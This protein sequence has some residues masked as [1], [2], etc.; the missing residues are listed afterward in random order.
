MSAAVA[1]FESFQSLDYI[2]VAATTAVCYDYTLTF[3]R[4]VEL[5]WMK[6]WSMVSTLFV[7][8]R[9]VGLVLTVI[10]GLGSGYGIFFMSQSACITVAQFLIW[11][12][13]VYTVAMDGI[14]ILRASVMFSQPKRIGCILSFLYSLVTVN[15]IVFTFLWYGP[16]SGL[17]V[18]AERLVDGTYC[19]TQ[20]GGSEIVSIYDGIPRVL[21]DILLMVLVIYRFTIH[22]IETQRMIARRKINKYM[23]LL[24][25]HSALYFLLNLAYGGFAT[26]MVLSSSTL[27]QMLAFL[28][29]STVPFMIYP[30]LVLS[31]KGYRAAS[32][33][34]YV[35][36][37]GPG[38][39]HSHSHSRRLSGPAV[40][41]G[42]Y[43]LSGMTLP[44]AFSHTRG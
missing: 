5:I 29:I 43:E 35:G 30:R 36:S 2:C 4:E 25:E 28:Y 21:F 23:R 27:Y 9:Y 38:Y 40:D 31:M 44:M 18:T 33:G 16:H 14:M 32:G 7:V 22:C 37:D 19:Y 24:L 10:S 1:V 12:K 20:S 15:T 34:L 13:V 11:A 6:P 39:L 41:S 8:A 17:V 3:S 42:V 26:G